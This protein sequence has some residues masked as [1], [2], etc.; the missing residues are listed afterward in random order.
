LRETPGASPAELHVLRVFCAEDGEAGNP[1]GLFLDDPLVAPAVRQEVASRL[2]FSETVFFEDVPQGRLKIFTPTREL[3][4]AGHPLVGAAWLLRE[5]GEEPTV[6]RPP[7]GEVS[8]RFEGPLTW[9]RARPEYSPPWDLLQLADASA[10]EELEG[11]PRELGHVQ[12][13]AW[14]DEPEGRV[15]AR[16]F[17]REYGVPEDPAT[18]SAAVVLCAHLGRE[19]S[20]TQGP[21][22][23][24]SAIHVRPVGHGWVELGG[25]V[26]RDRHLGRG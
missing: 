26:V 4:F 19:L 24:E 18:G 15:R 8:V 7:A 21:T 25:R 2:G 22:G 3:P 6:L 1:L 10:V 13:W 14:E 23:R 16:V 9:V 17:A 20:V 11:P 5:C 12:A